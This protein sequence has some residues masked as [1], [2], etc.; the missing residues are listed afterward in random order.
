MQVPWVVLVAC[1]GLA[2]GAAVW[3]LPSPDAAQPILPDAIPRVAPVRADVADRERTLAALTARNLFA[4]DGRA[5]LAPPMA[6][7][8]D[9]GE[10]GDTTDSTVKRA[11]SAKANAV[12]ITNPADAPAGMQPAL[13]NLLL[14]GVRVDPSGTPVAMIS[15]ASNPDRPVAKEYRAGDEFIDDKAPAS[16]WRVVEVDPVRDRVT[17]DRAGVRFGISLY[18]GEPAPAPEA[19][20]APKT[21]GVAAV[22]AAPPAVEVVRMSREDIIAQLR[23]EGITEQEIAELMKMAEAD[24]EAFAAMTKANAA[25]EPEGLGSVFQLMQQASERKA[26]PPEKDPPAVPPPPP[27]A[28]R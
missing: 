17:L 23:A 2:V 13:A 12:I 6:E 21:D 1:I 11:K 26:A 25:P 16:A 24:P 8:D 18:S 27:P 20:A 19:S 3:P 7:A 5:W 15:F 9:T 10:P 4:A 22:P 14:V 28:P